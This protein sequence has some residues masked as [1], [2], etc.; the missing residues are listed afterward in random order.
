MRKN[1]PRLVNPTYYPIEEVYKLLDES[2]TF[3]IQ[4]EFYGKITCLIKRKKR[5]KKKNKTPH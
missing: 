3:V 5:R 2:Y 1:N 4:P